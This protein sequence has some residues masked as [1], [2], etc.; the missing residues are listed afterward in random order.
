[1]NCDSVECKTFQENR[2]S[3]EKHDIDKHNTMMTINQETSLN[4]PIIIVK[5]TS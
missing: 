3:F 4:K 1:M 2:N 5:L